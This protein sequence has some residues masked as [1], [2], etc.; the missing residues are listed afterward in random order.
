[1]NLYLYFDVQENCVSPLNNGGKIL[2]SFLAG[3]LAGSD[4]CS[5]CQCL[6]GSVAGRGV[7]RTDMSAGAGPQPLRFAA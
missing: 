6:T 5:P 2:D 4:I 1:M 7:R 3:W